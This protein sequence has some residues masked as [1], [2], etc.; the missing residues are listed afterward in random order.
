M[1]RIWTALCHSID[2]L[3]LV[4]CAAFLLITTGCGML[5]GAGWACLILGSLLLGLVLVGVPTG[6][7]GP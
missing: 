6:K 5:W 3:D 7:R 1:T 2:L 4:L